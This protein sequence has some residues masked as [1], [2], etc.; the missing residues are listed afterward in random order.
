MLELQV[1]NNVP[2]SPDQQT[3]YVLVKLQV[4]NNVP[5]TPD[6]QIRYV[7]VKL[8]VS[9]NVS[10]SPRSTNQICCYGSADFKCYEYA[11]MLVL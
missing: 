6:P 1:S 11:D 9:N 10:S 2:S 5:S 8:Q 7:L 3:R 4:S